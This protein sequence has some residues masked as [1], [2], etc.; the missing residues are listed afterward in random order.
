LQNKITW[1]FYGKNEAGRSK[2]L[3]MA[4]QEKRAEQNEII[5]FQ[6][7]LAIETPESFPAGQ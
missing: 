5:A 4:E 1:Q 7:N 3:L 6:A 2:L